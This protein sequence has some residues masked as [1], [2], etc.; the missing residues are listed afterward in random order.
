MPNKLCSVSVGSVGSQTGSSLPSALHI[1]W[2]S[3]IPAVG[4]GSECPTV[5]GSVHCKDSVAPPVVTTEA[6]SR[7][8]KQVRILACSCCAQDRPVKDT[9]F[10]AA[11][12]ASMLEQL[13]WMSMATAQHAAV[14]ATALQCHAGALHVDAQLA[15]SAALPTAE[16]YRRA[17]S[18]SMRIISRPFEQHT[19]LVIDQHRETRASRL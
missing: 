4:L 12:V 9:L 2:L 19:V 7:T 16:V 15:Y 5:H 18:F 11:C 3:T 14:V 13:Q 6:C 17:V 10:K 1:Q 8:D